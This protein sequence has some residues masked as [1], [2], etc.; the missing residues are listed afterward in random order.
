MPGS[1]CDFGNKRSLLR[2]SLSITA[3]CATFSFLPHF[4]LIFDLLLNRRTATWNV[5]VKWIVN[6]VANQRT[7]FVRER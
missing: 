6:S 1:G 4:N 2:Y 7:A 3:L 5:F